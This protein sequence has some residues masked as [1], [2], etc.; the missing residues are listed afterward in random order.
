MSTPLETAVQAFLDWHEENVGAPPDLGG[1]AVAATGEW[2]AIADLR[3]ALTAH[4]AEAGPWYVVRNTVLR[5]GARRRIVNL[6][7]FPS[8]EVAEDRARRLQS[9]ESSRGVTFTAE[10]V[11]VDVVLGDL[12]ARCDELLA[13][14]GPWYVI[15]ERVAP[16]TRRECVGPFDTR[17]AAER[18][19]GI[20]GKIGGWT[21]RL[22]REPLVPFPTPAAEAPA[23]GSDEEPGPW[24]VRVS[25]PRHD[26]GGTPVE[27]VEDFGPFAT[28]GAARKAMRDVEPQAYAAGHSCA[29]VHGMPDDRLLNRRVAAAMP[30]TGQR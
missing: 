17:D 28:L 2:K 20:L 13:E 29:I 12:A 24:T 10:Q 30:R 6:G 5:D 4:R 11:P 9:I 14:A 21:V 16:T 3:A 15:Q 7:P 26:R 25:V 18:H 22:S 27:V 1:S 19:A 23:P 8:R